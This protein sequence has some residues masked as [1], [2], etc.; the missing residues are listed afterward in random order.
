MSINKDKSTMSYII[1][2]LLD[3]KK[4]ILYTSYRDNLLKE[5]KIMLTPKF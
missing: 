1:I 4:E 3:F 5:N 2:E